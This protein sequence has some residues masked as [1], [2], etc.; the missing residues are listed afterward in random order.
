[1]FAAA[2]MMGSQAFFTPLRIIG[3]MVLGAA[4][5]EPTYSLFAAV[6]AWKRHPSNAPVQFVVA[7]AFIRL[8]RRLVPRAI[9]DRHHAPAHSIDSGSSVLNISA[10]TSLK[11]VDARRSLDR[12][13]D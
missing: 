6:F 13:S 11:N 3:A 8:A 9:A 7:H 12:S 5:I 4:A 1:M 2:V 10:R